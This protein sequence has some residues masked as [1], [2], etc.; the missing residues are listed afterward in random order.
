MV[1]LIKKTRQHRRDFIGIYRCESCGAEAEV[2]HGYDDRNFHDNVTPAMTCEEC[3]E[4][5]NSLGLPTVRVPTRY[6]D[7]EVI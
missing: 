7:Q 4:S 5:T 3:G 6:G 1:R 2:R